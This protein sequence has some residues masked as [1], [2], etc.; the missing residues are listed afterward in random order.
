[1]RNNYISIF[2]VI[3]PVM[4]GPSSSHTSGAAAIAWTARQIFTGTPVRVVFTLYGSFADTYQGHGTDRALVGGLLGYRPYDVRIRDS[5]DHAREE[6]LDFSF[7][8]DRETET[9]HPNTVD[10]FMESGDKHTLLVRGESIGG[11][12]IR[13][14]RMND[15]DVD[16][17]GE[18][19]T[20]II[21]HEDK[22]G[23]AA[24]ITG[25]LSDH[26][27]NIA[28]M[29]L[30]RKEKGRLTISVIESDEYI[31]AEA[32][33]DLLANEQVNSVDLIEV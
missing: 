31:P 19:S 24:Y 23:V 30:F 7:V 17:T 10:V 28:F 9:K 33:S 12:R 29:K 4:I 22:P 6:G 32:V 11:G 18:Y 14:V 21:G 25:I 27:V 3:G 5:F 1:M 20:L 16:F 13:I 8:I 2:D 26:D 15:I